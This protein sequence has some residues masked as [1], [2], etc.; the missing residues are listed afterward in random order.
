MTLTPRKDVVTKYLER[1]SEPESNFGLR[2]QRT[3]NHVLV[4]PVHD[5]SASF[6]DGIQPALRTVRKRGD[7]TLCVL[8]VNATDTHH[9]GVHVR[10]EA[11]IESLRLHGSA[12][13]LHHCDETPCW[14]AEAD[15]YDLIILDRNSSGHRL[16]NREGVGL[17]R[18]IGCDVALAAIRTGS[19]SARL[20][21]MS[22]CDVSLPN[23]YFYISVPTLSAAVIYPFSHEP[24]GDPAIDEA[25]ARYESYLRYYIL[26]L[27]HA[28]SAYDFHTI[29]S[30][31]ATSPAMYAA[32]R[33]VPKRQ[34]GEDFY[35]LNKLAKLGRIH[36]AVSA[37]IKI[38]ARTS[39][40]VPFGTGQATHAIAQRI[41]TYRIYDPRIFDLLKA[42]LDALAILGDASP[43][44]VYNIAYR[45]AAAPLESIDR[46]RLSAALIAINVPKA[47]GEAVLQSS[48]STVRHK[49]IH[50]WL[51]A[52]RTLKLVHA[53]RNTGLVD[54]PWREAIEAAPFCRTST[55]DSTS[56]NVTE[57]DSFAICRRLA[58]LE[59]RPSPVQCLPLLD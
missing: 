3:T 37:P 38:R 7:R 46:D 43:T 48:S 9:A 39:L 53:L 54:I 28:G 50:D 22:D 6:L 36:S 57:T 23:D 58:K 35:L 33:G 24:I 15:G 55:T 30:C 5:E 40:R 52:F 42:W 49:W 29:G 12:V 18:K 4:I 14:Y 8:V 27:R 13:P 21:H 20:I 44:D 59:E 51:D 31:I 26:G 10:N 17:A 34:A 41:E 45:R 16:P 47:I 25:H 56:A 11:L 32:V 1:Y 19:S 2:V